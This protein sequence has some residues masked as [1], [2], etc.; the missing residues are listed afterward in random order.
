MSHKRKAMVARIKAAADEDRSFEA[1][2]TTNAVDRDHEVLL[3]EGMDATEWQRNPVIF[4]NHDYN[5]PIAKGTDLKR[6]K[7]Q[8][9]ATGTIAS[10]PTS[11][12]GEWFPDTI[13]SLMQQEIVRGVSVGFAPMERR[14][15]TP[16]DIDAF[17]KDVELVH[18]RWKLYEFS[19]TPLPANQ[20]ALITSVAKGLVPMTAY[21]AFGIAPPPPK[22]RRCIIIMPPAPVAARP[23]VSRAQL[24]SA[25]T[26]AIAR[27]C[28]KL[29]V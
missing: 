11:H 12:E 23:R 14:K 13:R 4:W 10:R 16:S 2:I 8:W 18:H 28:G 19:V 5:I 24:S 3:P 21:E 9:T 26:K 6:T 17:G 20:E 1:V 29:K 15:P 7:T 27:R 25:I 22:K